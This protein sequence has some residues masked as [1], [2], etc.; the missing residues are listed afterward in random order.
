MTSTNRYAALST[1]Q[2][3]PVLL[4]SSISPD[5]EALE[6]SDQ[7][8]AAAEEGWEIVA[9]PKKQ[10][11]KLSLGE[12]EEKDTNEEPEETR[13]DDEVEAPCATDVIGD[14]ATKGN[15]TPL[16]LA[17][18][19]STSPA[20]SLAA[21]S[22][23]TGEKP[24][25]KRTRGKKGGKK[26]NKGITAMPEAIQVASSNEVVDNMKVSEDIQTHIST[27]PPPKLDKGRMEPFPTFIDLLASNC[28]DRASVPEAVIEPSPLTP[29][30]ITKKPVHL[31]STNTRA[32]PGKI[33]VD[34]IRHDLPG[35]AIPPSSNRN[36]GV[37]LAKK[38]AKRGKKGSQTVQKRDATP[39]P[40]D[41][42]PGDDIFV[43][44]GMVTVVVVAAIGIC[45]GLLL[46]GLRT[47]V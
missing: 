2:S 5:S 31:Q 1:G 4:L 11:K 41:L 28:A 9:A 45:V 21:A 7:E 3:K 6:V 13:G 47:L 46:M 15:P 35:T 10:K 24:K 43:A 37:V 44:C 38:K 29:P 23:S 19:K 42:E 36:G 40:G 16:P 27:Y 26:F 33:E 20:S 12:G 17:L 34:G 18:K 22:E 14:E 25:K 32:A 39:T 30:T 8:E